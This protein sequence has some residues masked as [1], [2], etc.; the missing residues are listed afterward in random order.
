MSLPSEIRRNLPI[1]E[2]VTMVTVSIWSK[3]NR[4]KRKNKTCLTEPLRF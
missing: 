1:D 4:S 2:A 3:M